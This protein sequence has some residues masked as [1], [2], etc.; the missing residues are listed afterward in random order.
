[1][2]E[3]EGFG[4]FAHNLLHDIPHKAPTD[5]VHNTPINKPLGCGVNP[6]TARAPTIRTK[7]PVVIAAPIKPE[8]MISGHFER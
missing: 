6:H 4:F 3:V 2:C 5:K 8:W 7:I 1:M